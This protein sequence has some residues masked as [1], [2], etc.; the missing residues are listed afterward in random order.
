MGQNAP[1]GP[2]SCPATEEKCVILA[3]RHWTFLTCRAN[4][5]Q[6]RK[7]ERKLEEQTRT[8]KRE[9]ADKNRKH[10]IKIRNFGI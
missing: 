2:F 7:Q 10:L 9:R 6:K 5:G 4:L 3:P 8:E 1:L